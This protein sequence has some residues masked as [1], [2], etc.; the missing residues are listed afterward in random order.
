MLRRDLVLGFAAAGAL[1]GGAAP[2]VAALAEAL[3]AG[4][5][6]QRIREAAANRNYQG[7]MT[8]SAG[9]TV[10]SSRVAHYVDGRERFERVEGLDGQARQQ[11]RHNDQVVTLWPATRI[12]VVEQQHD[13]SDF[14]ALPP[15]ARQTLELYDLRL[16]GVER[17]CGLSA[18]VL[19]LKP[20]DAHRFA[21]RLWAEH[22]TGLLLRADML[23]AKGEV[24]ETSAFSQVELAPKPQPESVRGPMK[25][26][27]GWRVVRPKVVKTRLE[28]EGWTLARPVPGFDLVS[29]SRRPLDSGGSFESAVDVVQAVFGDGLAQVS[30]FVEP[31]DAQRHKPMRSANGA[32]HTA[33]GRRDDWWLTVMGEVPMATA[34][35][36]DAALER[37]H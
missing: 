23:G 34:L 25:R 12:A 9:G 10:S 11:Y 30:V 26:L 33:M 32:T 15:A 37:R 24:L 16:A 4:H 27:D 6:L 20:R 18:D 7:T 29:C 14:P 36:F 28:S 22:D 3:P 35:L 5:W 1:A 17:A 2:V 13:A 8:F 19:V 21:Q 31:Y